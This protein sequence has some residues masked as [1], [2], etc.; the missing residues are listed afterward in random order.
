MW[1]AQSLA[2]T[3]WLKGSGRRKLCLCLLAFTLIW[4]PHLLCRCSCWAWSQLLWLPTEINSKLF[5]RN[6]SGHWCQIGID[7]ASSFTNWTT[8]GFLASLVWASLC[9][10]IWTTLNKITNPFKC[11]HSISLILQRMWL[12]Y[13]F[14]ELSVTPLSLVFSCLLQGGYMISWCWGL[15][16]LCAPPYSTLPDI[17]NYTFLI[18]CCL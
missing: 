14:R 13:L 9:W 11:I 10:I 16:W 6:P 15:V 2:V 17:R 7:K 1:T 4:Q 12:T 8:T 3:A 5:S 18:C